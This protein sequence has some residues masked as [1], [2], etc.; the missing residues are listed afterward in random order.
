MA[1]KALI[2]YHSKFG[3]RT[4]HHGDNSD[5]ETESEED[6]PKQ[7]KVRAT[8]NDD[9][10]ETLTVPHPMSSIIRSRIDSTNSNDVA[11]KVELA[12]SPEDGFLPFCVQYKYRTKTYDTCSSIAFNWNN[13]NYFMLNIVCACVHVDYPNREMMES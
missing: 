9:E 10:P 6:K 12:E 2:A 13:L 7:W 11:V 8:V 3:F 1:V 5:D 4:P